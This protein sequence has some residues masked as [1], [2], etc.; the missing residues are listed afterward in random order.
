LLLLPVPL[1]PWFKPALPL[2]DFFHA[3]FAPTPQGAF[4]QGFAGDPPLL[5]DRSTPVEA[6]E[7]LRHSPPRGKLF[8]DMVFGSYINW[9]LYPQTRSLCDPRIELYPLKWWE[10]FYFRLGKGPADAAQILA[11][12][13]YSD[14]LLDP[15]M[16]PQLIK[17]LQA[18]PRWTIVF[19]AKASDWPRSTAVVVRHTSR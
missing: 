15:K 5:L 11:R 2:P 9:M 7:F 14:A 16:Q 10:G 19:P 3:R 13:G 8:N 4:S 17:R 12:D 6:V 1:L 18:A